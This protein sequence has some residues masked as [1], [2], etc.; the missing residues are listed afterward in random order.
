MKQT[1][2]L[3]IARLGAG[4][5]L[6]ALI[7][8]AC[9][10]PPLPAR[11]P[12]SSPLTN[13]DAPMT[14]EPNN[15]TNANTDS[16]DS[17]YGATWVLASY[18]DAS[19]GTVPALEVASAAITFENGRAAGSVGCNRISGPYQVNDNDITLGPFMMT[20]M[21]CPEPQMTQEQAVTKAMA[22]ATTFE[23]SG[24]QLLLKNAA[25]EVVV[26][27]TKDM[28]IALI[29]PE[30]TMTF[31]NN[32]KGGFQSAVIGLIVTATFS[33]DGHVSGTGG[34]NSYGGS[35]TIEGN[36]ISFGSIAATE[37]ACME[38]GVMAQEAAYFQA[39]G[40][41]QRYRIEGDRLTFYGA[42]TTR[43]VE[44]VTK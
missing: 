26:T 10:V 22:D 28:P 18:V 34:C 4:S 38:E 39:L 40:N 36:T 42:G 33:E 13:Q 27:L 17:L 31:Y 8:V 9:A 16:T 12:L 19:G 5:I 44:Y 35:F 11:P 41:V 6:T 14:T 25:G 21:A 43:M 3:R 30:W 1:Q 7:A 37:K 15:M 20:M 23:I 32:G 24:D 29:G 2:H